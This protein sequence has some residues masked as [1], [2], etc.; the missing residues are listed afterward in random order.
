[1]KKTIS[2]FLSI[3]LLFSVLTVAV[4]AADRSCSCGKAPIILIDGMNA[5]NLIRDKGAENERVAFPFTADD[6][7]ALI[8]DNKDAVWDMLDGDFSK[9][10]ENAVA[11]GIEAM[12]ADIAMRDDGT[13]AYNVT[14]DWAYPTGDV[15]KEGGYF[16]YQYDWRLDPFEVAAGLRDFTEYVKDLTGHDTVHFVGFSQGAI[17]LNTYLSLYG[18][19]GIE[20]CVWYCGAH[21]GVEMVGQLY[22]GRYKVDADAAAGYVHGATE[23][24]FEFELL[25]WI[26]QG[27][28]DIGVTG[29]ILKITNKILKLMVKDGTIADITRETFGKMP[30]IWAMIDDEYY[31]DAKT[32]IFGDETERYSALIEKTDRY[33]YDVQARSA[34][35]MENARTAAGRIGVITK[36]GRRL[37]PVTEDCDVQSDGVIDARH[38][39]C[40]ATFADFGKTLA[41]ASGEQRYRSADGIVDASTALYPDYTWFIKNVEHS[42]G[43]DYADELVRYISF[44]DHQPDVSENPAYPQFSVYSKSAGETRPLTKDTDESADKKTVVQ[45]REFFQRIF[46]AVRRFFSGIFAQV[47]TD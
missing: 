7:K 9:E 28:T 12:L 38:T 29:G 27:L 46:E 21:N 30:A 24:T 2:V 45:I 13:P 10:S 25:S 11:E 40:G 22:T 33:H 41:D 36:Y 39:S 1:M 4:P 35:I 37:I 5:R 34:E 31:E 16:K 3:L 42:E 15:H 26:L 44:A 14:I 47:S 20:S 32:F 19:D 17:T 6:I 23:N 8:T 18:Y 43:C